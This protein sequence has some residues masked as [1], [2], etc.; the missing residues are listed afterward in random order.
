MPFAVSALSIMIPDRASAG[1]RMRCKAPLH[2]CR[3]QYA[4]PADESRPIPS[5]G[6]HLRRS[7][8]YSK[9]QE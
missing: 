4:A 8:V 3:T 9:K 2:A 6:D 5:A 1:L 7:I